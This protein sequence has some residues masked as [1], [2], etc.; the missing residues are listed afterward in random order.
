MGQLLGIPSLTYF[1]DRA[2][3]LLPEFRS[4]ASP[5]SYQCRRPQV[6]LD[7]MNA[8]DGPG[9]RESS[10]WDFRGPDRAPWLELNRVIWQ[11]VKGAAAEPPA[12]VFRVAY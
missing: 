10:Q 8:K 11:S 4:E 9:A 12:P 6:S 5:A 7:E 2:P 1:D 3:S